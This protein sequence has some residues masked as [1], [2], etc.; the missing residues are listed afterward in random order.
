MLRSLCGVIAISVCLVSTE[1][2][3]QTSV[4][5]PVGIDFSYAGYQAGAA[6]PPTIAAVISV[7]PSGGDDTDLLQSAIDHVA[8]MPPDSR[9]YRGAIVLR[10]GRFHVAGKL[11]LNASGVALRGSG[12]GSTTIVA[13]GD[14][15]RTLI[16]IGGTADPELAAAITVS[17]DAPPGARR[18]RLVSTEGLAVGVRVVVRRPSTR[19][20]ISAIGMSG[21]P[22][23]FA[24]QRLDW[25]PGSH[26]LIWDRTI[27]AVDASANEIELD[28]P[29]TTALEAKYGG[30]TVA[31]LVVA[32]PE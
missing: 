6:A 18:L 28:A 22:G 8:A 1:G 4:A 15:R 2:R 11:H 9:G 3:A 17:G 10:P 14:G 13:E 19:E 30:G 16:E 21:L 24:S 20:W 27:T 7:R 5:S 12:A 31:K 23:T 29:I 32:D 25:Q 26:D